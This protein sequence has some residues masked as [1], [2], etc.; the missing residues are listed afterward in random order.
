MSETM[1]VKHLAVA[2]EQ[3]DQSLVAM[4]DV[5]L[6]LYPG[7]TL[8]LLGESGCGKSLTSLALMRLLPEEAAYGQKSKVL[9]GRDDILELPEKQ[10]RSIRGR[11]MAMIFQEPM[12][13]L[14]PVLTIGQQLA[15]S[16]SK[17]HGLSKKTLK[18]RMIQ[19]LTE[20]DISEPAHRLQ[21]YPHQLS[22]GQKQ[23]VV[24]A[25]ALAGKPDVL[26]ADEP[27]TALDATTQAQILSLLK[28]LQS[29]YQ[30]SILLITH[31]LGVVKAM[32]DRVCVM[33]A[34]QLVEV[35]TVVPFIGEPK[36]PYAQQLLTSLPS[37]SK[38]GERLQAIPGCVPT[39]DA[40]TSGCR[41]H[42]RCAH[43]FDR[44]RT[45]PPEIQE[46][47][48]GRLVRC[49][50][51]PSHRDLPAL[52]QIK[53]QW[54]PNYHHNDILISVQDLAVYFYPR[55]HFLSAKPLP[56]KAVDGLSFDLHRGK[57]LALVGESGC[58]KST[59]CKALLR[60]QPITRGIMRYQD[61]NI[62]LLHGRGLRDFRKKVQI[63]LQD[64]F[65][66]MNPRMT[67]ADILAEGMLAQG[68]RKSIIRT[69]LL[70]L[71]DQ[72]NLPKNS[73]TR[74]PH[75]FSGG[76]RQR[77]C[78]ARALATN[79]EV[80]VCDEPTSALDISVQAQILNLLKT[81][82]HELGL[83]YLF[84][85]HNMS[86]VS[87]MADDVLVMR[88]G[89]AIETGACGAVLTSPKMEYTKVLLNSSEW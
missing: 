34:G 62:E 59:V 88:N 47:S 39:L 44:C 2:F 84:I 3:A 23:R 61:T 11:R 41:F 60:L 53:D 79:P 85:T 7:E 37:F 22:G 24:I 57:T 10:M 58:G 19:L 71:L 25:M 40:R 20:V 76:Q 33:Y 82:Q 83:S 52:P 18:E 43:A 30:M 67:I 51:Y 75:Q 63:I 65:A 73:L 26:I 66:S 35:S 9:F 72:V 42:P 81:L 54:A 86:V 69:R 50:L 6:N 45:D 28:Q 64:P 32:A 17:A 70:A 48:D 36:H 49:H 38:R 8:A 80:L 21:Q 1:V 77:I 87:Y 56:F 31:D 13:A 14:N 78:I 89:K 15:E 27:T 16:I 4:D 68:M 46:L 74:Y 29:R 55:R 5:C 12:T